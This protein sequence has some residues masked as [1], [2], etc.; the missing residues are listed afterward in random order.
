VGV[1]HVGHL[2]VPL[3]AVQVFVRRFVGALGDLGFLQFELDVAGHL[4]D[5]LDPRQV[6]SV[7][8]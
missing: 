5:P 8:G 3:Q 1:S 6:V 7:V 4:P 2:L